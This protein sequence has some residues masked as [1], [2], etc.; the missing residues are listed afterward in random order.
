MHLNIPQSKIFDIIGK[1]GAGKSS[2]IRTLSGLEQIT[3]GSIHIDEHNLDELNHNQ[4]IQLRQR[5]GMVFHA[6]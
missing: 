5:I 3:S 6:R 2:L 1:T 4:L